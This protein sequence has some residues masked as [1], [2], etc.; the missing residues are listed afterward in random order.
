[1]RKIFFRV[2]YNETIGSGHIL[3]C[4]NLIKN[5]I[6]NNKIILITRA[7]LNEK[8]QIK[9]I[10][11]NMKIDFFFL[12][13]VYKINKKNYS[14]WLRINVKKDALETKQIINNCGGQADDVIVIDHYGINNL[15]LKIL[16]SKIKTI[17][18]DDYIRR[19][20]NSDVIINGNIKAKSNFYKKNLSSKIYE[21]TKYAIIS[22]EYKSCYKLSHKKKILIFFS[23]SD[24][25]QFYLKV[26]KCFNNFEN[27]LDFT[28]ITGFQNKKFEKN[29]QKKNVKFFENIKD[30]DKIIQKTTLA[31]GGCGSTYL[32]RLYYNIPSIIF[33]LS[34]NQVPF[35][36]ILHKNKIS[37]YLGSEKQ[38]KEKNLISKIKQFLFDK[39]KLITLSDNSKKFI[40]DFSL[41]RVSEIISPSKK[42]IF[43]LKKAKK[44]HETILFHWVN[45]INVVKSSISKKAISYKE[46]CQWYKE[47]LKNKKIKIFIFYM[48]DIPIGQIRFNR[49]KNKYIID[50]SLDSFV[51]GR[52]YGSKLIKMGI[53]KL[54]NDNCKYYE[55]KVRKNNIISQKIF[56]KLNFTTKNTKNFIIFKYV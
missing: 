45:D 39:S 38:F 2:D 31:I 7:N 14:T 54:K 29:I 13:P 5:I 37:I 19:R 20:I 18:L 33:S 21:G 16:N 40:D 35:C 43:S 25:N 51:R 47:S 6:K 10:F 48:N 56:R 53:K 44:E 28:I 4:M 55:A 36:K 46:H 27:D 8:N 42:I 15:W 12:Q 3:R 50:Y 26:L 24:I 17:V 22:P 1:M 23:N 52:G 34:K 41:K 49:I 9:K 30:F 32:Q 11:I